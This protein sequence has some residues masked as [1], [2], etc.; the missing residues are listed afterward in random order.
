MSERRPQYIYD[1]QQLV[2]VIEPVEGGWRL[3]RNGRE[4]GVYRS[5]AEALAAVE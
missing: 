2:A 5:R 3:I 4:V 1:D